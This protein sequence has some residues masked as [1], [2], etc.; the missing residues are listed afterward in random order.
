VFHCCS[1]CICCATHSAPTTTWSVE[2][3]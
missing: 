2:G 3:V 1:C